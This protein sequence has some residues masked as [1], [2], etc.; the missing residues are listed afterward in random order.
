MTASGYEV[1][2]WEDESV[3]MVEDY[4]RTIGLYIF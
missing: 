2:A 4:S 1:S 3:L